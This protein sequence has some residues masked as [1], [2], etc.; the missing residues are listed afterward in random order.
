LK[1]PV[2]R[3]CGYLPLFVSV[4][5]AGILYGLD[6]GEVLP[7]VINLRFF[8]GALVIAAALAYGWLLHGRRETLPDGEKQA[9][10]VHFMISGVLPLVLLSLEFHR[11]FLETVGDSQRADYLALMSLSVIWAVY[12]ACGLILGFWRNWQ[13][14]RLAALALFG[15]TCVKVVLV[16]MSEVKQVYRIVSFISLGLLMIGASYL[17]HRLEQRLK[18]AEMPEKKL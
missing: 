13:P 16:D 5:I 4:I 2:R 3:I 17:Y 11:F 18:L 6:F 10:P 8:V 14:V 15:I 9:I 7:L 12:A 1:S